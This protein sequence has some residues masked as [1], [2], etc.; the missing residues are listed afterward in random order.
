MTFQKLRL[1]VINYTGYK[2]FDNENYRKGLITLALD[3]MIVI[4]LIFFIYVK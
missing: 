2:N 1:R 3:L 4:S